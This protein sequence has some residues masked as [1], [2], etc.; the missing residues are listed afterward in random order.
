MLFF[1]FLLSSLLGTIHVALFVENK[2]NIPLKKTMPIGALLNIS[3]IFSYMSVQKTSFPVAMLFETCAVVPVVLV[4]VFCSRVK[5]KKVKLGPKKIIVTVI[6][7]VGVI[8][9]KFFDP[10]TWQRGGKQEF[11]GFVF[12]LVT[13]TCQGFVPDLQA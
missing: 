1:P 3:T 8:I 9:F 13:F 11:L 7:T 12:I 10:E 2:V 5:D 6:T 4:G